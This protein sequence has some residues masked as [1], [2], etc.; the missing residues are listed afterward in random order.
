MTG[1]M[2][3]ENRDLKEFRLCYMCVMIF[4]QLSSIHFYSELGWTDSEILLSTRGLLQRLFI[5]VLGFHCN[6]F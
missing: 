6:C 3:S 5:H 2:S 1:N 4:F